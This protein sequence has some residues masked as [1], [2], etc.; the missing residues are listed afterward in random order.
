[1]SGRTKGNAAEREV[2][3]L[4]QAW[5]RRFEPECEFIRTPLSGG[6]GGPKLRGE[7]GAAGDLM[8][9]AKFFPLVIEVKRREGWAWTRLL[10]A[11]RPS[12]VWNWWG[13]AQTQALEMNKVPS[14]WIRK[15][16]EKLWH[17]MIPRCYAEKWGVR[18]KWV[19]GTT[20]LNVGISP[21][22]VTI[23]SLF[24]LHPRVFIN[25]A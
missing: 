14:L 25:A 6:W 24:A 15:N 5:W 1:M 13:Q 20:E 3:K 23:Q 9:T 7:F 19:W 8:T 21:A 10:E 11:S 18:I 2:A 4:V 16:R 22:L 17:V 12:P